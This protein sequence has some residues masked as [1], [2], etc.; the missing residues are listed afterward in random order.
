MAPRREGRAPRRRRRGPLLS[1]HLP[2]AGDDD[3]PDEPDAFDG[4]QAPAP[5]EPETIV[6]EF[7]PEAGVDAD[8]GLG[9]I[10]CGNSCRSVYLWQGP[11]DLFKER[12]TKRWVEYHE[13]ET[14]TAKAPDGRLHW[15]V[16][17]PKPCRW[18]HEESPGVF[19]CAVYS[20]RPYVC[21]I[22]EGL[23]PDGPPPGCGYNRTGPVL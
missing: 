11:L 21:R 5:L 7:A 22:Y 2:R 17:L 14:F 18:L 10:R 1:A 15:G 3:E 9:C 20:T 16:K 19:A 8:R 23:N 13:I 6:S 4:G 12:D